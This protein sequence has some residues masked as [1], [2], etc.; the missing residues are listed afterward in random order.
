MHVVESTSSLF[1]RRSESTSDD[2]STLPI[3]PLQIASDSLQ[4]HHAHLARTHWTALHTVIVATLV[5]MVVL[6]SAALGVTMSGTA[7]SIR[8]HIG[9][10]PPPRQQKIDHFVVLFME[11]RAFDHLIGCMDL[12]GIDGIPPEGLLIPRDPTN[13]TKGFANVSC[14]TSPYVCSGSPGYSQ[15]RAKFAPEADASAYPYGTQGNEYS[16][17]NGAS[18]SA[19]HMFSA[20]QQPVKHALARAF[21]VFNKLYSAVP[22]WSSPNHLFAQ[23]GTSC[24]IHDNVL[25]SECG[26]STPT[27]PM[28]TIYDSLFLHHVSFA[29]YMNSTCGLD[30]ARPCGGLDV[31]NRDA[32][33]AVNSPDVGMDGVGRYKERFFS[34]TQ[35]Y[36]DAARG[37][38]P[39]FSW[40]SPPLQA[41]DHPCHDVAKGERFIKDVYEALRAGPGWMKTLLLVVYDDGGGFYDHVSCPAHKYQMCLFDGLRASWLTSHACAVTGPCMRTGGATI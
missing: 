15:F 34:Q 9:S 20:A 6:L 37:K 21:G 5:L 30:G 1:S 22:G 39:A 32:P 35:F 28:M 4:A 38:L 18:G 40:I 41:S 36:A 16:Y 2:V 3:V 13:L 10:R 23:S 31:R 25:Y 12:P 27:F 26:G 14:G 8:T 7:S 11:N 24:G 29:F 19:L 33:S 17:H